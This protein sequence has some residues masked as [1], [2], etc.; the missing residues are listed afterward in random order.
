[1]TLKKSKKMGR[2]PLP[3]GE[4][5]TVFSVRFS[6]KERKAVEKAAKKAEEPV[7]QWAR[8]TLLA[9]AQ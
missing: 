4:A 9:A 2:P 8:K 5:R 6:E 7:T 3:E 1:M